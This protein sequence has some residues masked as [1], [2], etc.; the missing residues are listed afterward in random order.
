MP[1][2]RTILWLFIFYLPFSV[3]AQNC[4]L[5]PGFEDINNCTE[6]QADCSPEAWFNMPAVAQ[7]VK[8]DLAPEPLLG[9]MVLLL[10]VANV[11]PN[12]NKKLRFVYTLLGCPLQEGKKYRLSFYI[13]T[14]S[15]PFEKLDFYFT[16]KEPTLNTFNAAVLT[17][18]FSITEKDKTGKNFH[19]W[20]QMQQDFTASANMSFCVIGNFQ[21]LRF[22]YQM[23]DAMNRSGDIF[24]FLDEIFLEPIDSMAICPQYTANQKIAYAQ[25][26]RHTDNVRMNFDSVVSLPPPPP[27]RLITDTVTIPDVL[28]DVNKALLKP[29]ITA[30]LDSL[31]NK[32]SDKQILKMEINGHTDNSGTV[33][34]NEALSLA[35][36]LCVKNYLEAK[37]PQLSG[38]IT[39]A[40][41]G[42][43]FPIAD[44]TT[45][46]GRQKNRRVEIILTVQ[47]IE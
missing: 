33:A 19:G 36:A 35:R 24:Y 42:Q 1:I 47:V 17:P 25:N 26:L 30:L 46:A 2:S 18:T 31:A 20:K 39:A 5:N 11:M 6:H 45:A 8:R 43:N 15:L 3:Q 34:K 40:G 12:F 22:N 28:F 14:G 13:N 10:P 29:A 38:N 9:N 4:F 21:P 44:N 27:P 16:D 32:L 7:V 41:K 37:L 23:G